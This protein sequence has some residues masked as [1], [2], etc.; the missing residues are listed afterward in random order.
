[1]KEGERE[2][3]KLIPLVVAGAFVRKKGRGEAEK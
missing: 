3:D 2:R 1:M